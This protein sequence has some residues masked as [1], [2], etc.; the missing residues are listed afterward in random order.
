MHPS[1]FAL[2]VHYYQR[3]EDVRFQTG[4]RRS[5]LVPCRKDETI[6]DLRFVSNAMTNSGTEVYP[7]LELRSRK[8][9]TN[10]KTIPGFWWNWMPKWIP[11]IRPIARW[12]ARDKGERYLNEYVI[13]FR[14]KSSRRCLPLSLLKNTFDS[15]IFW[16]WTNPFF[17][18]STN[19]IVWYISWAMR[20]FTRW[21]LD[22]YILIKCF[23]LKYDIIP[24]SKYIIEIYSIK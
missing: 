13:A 1:G 14:R 23:Y 20:N 7:T 17:V 6:V 9:S 5:V 10:L 3:E 24:F 4:R 12:V 16:W 15:R 18:R 22:V 19:E 8:R 21:M 11:F 2:W